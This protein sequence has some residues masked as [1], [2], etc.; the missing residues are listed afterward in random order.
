MLTKPR[1]KLREDPHPRLPGSDLPKF[2]GLLRKYTSSNFMGSSAG[3]TESEAYLAKAT[4]HAY[5]RLYRRFVP[6]LP[7]DTTTTVWVVYG[8]AGSSFGFPEL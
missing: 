2:I 5:L 6:G 4:H 1:V 8:D 7:M 3:S